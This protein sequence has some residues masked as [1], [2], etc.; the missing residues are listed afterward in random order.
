MQTLVILIH[1]RK[2]NPQQIC[3]QIHNIVKLWQRLE[4]I[5]V[6]PKRKNSKYDHEISQQTR[7]SN[8]LQPVIKRYKQ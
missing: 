6:K 5:G 2:A 3:D 4:K 1:T 7:G 8:H